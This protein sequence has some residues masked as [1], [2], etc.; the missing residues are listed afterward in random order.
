MGIPK[1]VPTFF[2]IVNFFRIGGKGKGDNVIKK[3]NDR[4]C[5][6]QW[7]FPNLFLLFGHKK[8]EF[9]FKVLFW[10]TN[11]KEKMQAWEFPNFELKYTFP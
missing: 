2:F 3:K 10:I 5:Y 8:W 11:F 9:M 6:K 1:I 7:E 4:F